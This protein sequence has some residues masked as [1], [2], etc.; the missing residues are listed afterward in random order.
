MAKDTPAKRA[1]QRVDPAVLRP[2]PRVKGDRKSSI[3]NLNLR[4]RG[5]TY[6]IGDNVEGSTGWSMGMDQA[7]TF[8]LPIRDPSGAIVDA[9]DDESNLQQD[10]VLVVLDGINYIVT[11]VD[12]DGEG[13]YTLTVE[14]EVAWR[15]KQFSKFMAASRANTTRFGFIQRMVDEAGRKPYGRIRSFIPEIADKQKIRKPVK[16]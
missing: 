10:G 13:L 7:S 6:P 12:H 1:R 5:R 4:A 15:L 2:P 14:D 8:A 16:Q 3:R 11:G 9:L